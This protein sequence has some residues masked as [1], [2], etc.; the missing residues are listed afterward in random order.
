MGASAAILR[1]L[2]YCCSY[3]SM[4]QNFTWISST[5]GTP[6]GEARKLLYLIKKILFIEF[7]SA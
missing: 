3:L 6:T 7:S 5:K 1:I 4:V 2:H